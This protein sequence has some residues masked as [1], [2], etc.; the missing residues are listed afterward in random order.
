MGVKVYSLNEA[1]E[2]PSPEVP[3]PTPGDVI[4]VGEAYENVSMLEFACLIHDYEQNMFEDVI[5]TDFME[6]VQEQVMLEADGEEAAADN[7]ADAGGDE[8]KKSIIS[9][10]GDAAKAIKDKVVELIRAFIRKIEEWIQKLRVKFGDLFK[11]DTKIAN[12]MAAM[13]FSDVEKDARWKA[14]N[15]NYDLMNSVFENLST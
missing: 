11:V 1:P 9:K 3:A 15:V 13:N 2:V 5:A 8:K 6:A 12:W 10:A 7:N 14:P 4:A